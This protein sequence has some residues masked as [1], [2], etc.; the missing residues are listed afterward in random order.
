MAHGDI[1]FLL[2]EAADRVEVGVVPVQAVVRGGRRRRTRRWALTATTAVA[3]CGATGATL[4]MA[5]DPGTDGKR[6]EPAAT[7]PASPGTHQ[8]DKPLVTTLAR[9]VDLGRQW[10]VSVEVWDAPRNRKEAENQTTAMAREGL[11]ST[12]SVRGDGRVG[13][14][15]YFVRWT[16]GGGRP[17]TI[18]FDT[19]GR[20]DPLRNMEFES[21]AA[22]MGGRDGQLVVGQVAKTA[23]QVAC[24]WKDGSS[25]VVRRA[26]DDP[27][28]GNTIRPA[29]GTPV[30]WFVCVAPKGTEMKSVGLN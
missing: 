16:Y 29:A 22:P 25:T 3:F 6:V 13:K 1:A 20:W 7:Q 23:R 4:A 27:G 8:V 17:E 19:V 18:M 24:S 12:G 28:S 11:P 2:A 30:D 9:G 5:W 15:S 21:A 14:T 10:R 26:S